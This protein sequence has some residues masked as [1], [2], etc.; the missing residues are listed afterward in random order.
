MAGKNKQGYSITWIN[1]LSLPKR[2]TPGNRGF[3][4]AEKSVYPFFVFVFVLV[5]VGVVFV[6]VFVS[7]FCCA[8]ADCVSTF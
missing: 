5:L 2:K 6:F 3:F 7:D 1:F 4:I 8:P